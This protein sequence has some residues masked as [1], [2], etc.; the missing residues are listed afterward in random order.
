M[1]IRIIRI[2][3][4]IAWLIATAAMKVISVDSVLS[5]IGGGIVFAILGAVAVGITCELKAG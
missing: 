1:D 5:S 4:R 2:V 3:G